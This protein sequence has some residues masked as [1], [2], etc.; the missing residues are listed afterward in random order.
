MLKPQK[1]IDTS[2]NSKNLKN[3][4]LRR[5]NVYNIDFHGKS[6]TNWKL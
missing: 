6:V 4:T 3:N 1:A 2:N 5:E